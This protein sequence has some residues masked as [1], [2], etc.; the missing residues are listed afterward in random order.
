M[1]SVKVQTTQT[2]ITTVSQ[3][4]FSAMMRLGGS[5]SLTAKVEKFLTVPAAE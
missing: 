2:R 5:F 4:G 1:S 3:S